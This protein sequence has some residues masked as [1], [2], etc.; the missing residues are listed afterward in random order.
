MCKKCNEKKYRVFSTQKG[1]NT[2]II[3]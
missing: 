1:N 2:A 3:L